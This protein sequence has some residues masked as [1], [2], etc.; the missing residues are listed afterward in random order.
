MAMRVAIYT[1]ISDDTEG[2]AK[3]VQRQEQDCRALA[4]RRGWSVFEPVRQDNDISAFNTKVVRPAFES[5]LDDLRTGAMTAS[6]MATWTAL[7]G[8]HQTWSEQSESSITVLHSC[9]PRSNPTWTS[10]HP[11]GGPWHE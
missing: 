3:G 5:L 6:D 8:N 11:T 2:F 10:Q 9:S 7:L 1:R 4:K